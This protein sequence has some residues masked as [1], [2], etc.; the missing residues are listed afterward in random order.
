LIL[1]L[2]ILSNLYLLSE[3]LVE[4][5]RESASSIRGSMHG[6]VSLHEK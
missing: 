5:E 6:Y 1:A 3:S 2:S 4:R